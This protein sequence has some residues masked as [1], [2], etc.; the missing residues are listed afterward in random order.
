[1][2]AFRVP[3][4]LAYVPM[5]V[6]GV[7]PVAGTDRLGDQLTVIAQKP[8]VEAPRAVHLLGGQ[9]PVFIAEAPR[10]PVQ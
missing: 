8:L 6:F 10:A 4:D 3:E 7:Y 9:K 5:Y 1:M 2:I